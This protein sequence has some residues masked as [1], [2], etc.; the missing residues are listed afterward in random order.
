MCLCLNLKPS[1]QERKGHESADA[2]PDV[3]MQKHGAQS[4]I[5]QNLLGMKEH[6][7]YA[8]LFL[9]QN[10]N[11]YFVFFF[12]SDY[13]SLVVQYSEC[14]LCFPQRVEMLETTTRHDLYV[15]T[16]IY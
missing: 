12:E 13:D 11:I 1:K 8:L 4:I 16:T 6:I 9:A 5:I 2:A 10:P 7:I 3:I 15:L 14:H